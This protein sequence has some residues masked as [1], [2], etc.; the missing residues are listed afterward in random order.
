MPTGVSDSGA[1]R[2]SFIYDCVHRHYPDLP[3]RAR[4]IGRRDAQGRLARCYFAAVGVAT[5]GEMRKLFQWRPRDIEAA[6]ELLVSEGDLIAV[7]GRTP[8]QTQF[9]WR[10]LLEENGGA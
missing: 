4:P 2:Y 7:P 9:V 8:S 3:A 10:Q 1:W 6:L 5:A